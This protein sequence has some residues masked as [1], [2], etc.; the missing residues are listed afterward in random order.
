MKVHEAITL[1]Q[2]GT[3]LTLMKIWCFTYWSSLVC[4]LSIWINHRENKLEDYNSCCRPFCLNYMYRVFVVPFNMLKYFSTDLMVS[5][6]LLNGFL[7]FW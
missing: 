3:M 6:N 5:F 1:E 4:V 2:V 7:I